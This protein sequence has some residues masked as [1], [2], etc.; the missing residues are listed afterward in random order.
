MEEFFELLAIQGEKSDQ[1]EKNIP[2]ALSKGG[3]MHV[4]CLAKGGGLQ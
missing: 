1:G 4:F 2:P 3:A